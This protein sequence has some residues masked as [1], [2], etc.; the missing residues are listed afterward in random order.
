MLTSVFGLG[1][2]PVASGTFG[3]MPTVIVFALLCFINAGVLVTSVVMAAI[4]L[5]FSFACVK[6]GDEIIAKAGKDDP[7]EIV[8]DEAAGQAVAFIGAYAAGTSN[9]LIVSAIGFFVFR[10]FDI[11]KPEPCRSLEKLHGGVGVLADDL[12]AGVYT[13]AVLQ[14]CVYLFK[15]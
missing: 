1:F 15:L 5:F 6:F 12:M 4:V 3:S 10:F 7:S 11:L 13:A 9:I 2:M 14:V 8:A